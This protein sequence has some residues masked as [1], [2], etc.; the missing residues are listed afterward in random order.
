MRRLQRGGLVGRDRIVATHDHLGGEL[1]EEMSEVVGERVVVVDEQNRSASGLRQLDRLRRALGLRAWPGARHAGRCRPR[2]RRLQQRDP[3][4]RTTVRIAMHVSRPTPGNEHRPRHGR[5]GGSSSSSEMICIA[6]TLGAPETVPAGNVARKRSNGET[7]S[8]SSPAT[9]E[10]RCVTCEKRSA[11]RKRSTLTVP[12]RQTRERSLRPRSTS[13]TCSAR[14]FSEGAAAPRRRRRASCPRS[15]SRRAFPRAGR[16]SRVTSRRARVE[17][18]QEEVRARFDPAQGAVD[19]RRRGA[20][21]PFGALR[22]NDLERVT[23][24]GCAPCTAR[25]GARGRPGSAKRSSSPPPGWARRATAASAS[26]RGQRAGVAAQHLGDRAGTWS[27]RTNTSATTN[28]LSG[29]VPGRR[30][31]AAPSARASRRGRSRDSRRPARRGSRPPRT[32]RAVRRS[33]RTSSGRAGPGRPTRAERGA[34]WSAQVEVG[35]ERGEEIG[36][37]DG[38]VVTDTNENDPLGSRVEQWRAV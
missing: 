17:L 28:R 21:A 1:A 5:R 6:R 12:G 19:A 9:S 2:S 10:T 30:P 32:R 14:S 15:G 26:H 18:Q 38:C 8:C 33:R 29:H 13:I 4:C 35:R 36:V 27:N 34:A 11:S 7:P 25:P 23:P 3:S 16:A 37:E 24:G 31:A 22:E 20:G